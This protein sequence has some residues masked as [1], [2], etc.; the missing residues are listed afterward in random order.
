MNFRLIRRPGPLA[1]AAGLALGLAVAGTSLAEP[2]DHDH[3]H[4]DLG[5]SPRPEHGGTVA[6]TDR[7]RFEVVFKADGLIL[8][9]RGNGLRPGA[10]SG[11]KGRAYFLLP[12]AS[13][14]SDP[15]E[16]RPVSTAEGGPADALGLDA[17][18]GGLPA[19]GTRV[20]I[21]VWKLP[22]P[23]EKT[24]QFTLPFA[25]GSP[26]KVVA[27]AAT[28]E[29][30]LGI[31][32][33]ET[34]PV[35]GQDL[36][37]MGGPLRVTRGEE[38]RLYLCCRGCLPKVE[39]APERSFN[40]VL[41]AREATGDDREAVTSQGTCPISD[42]DLDAMGGPIEVSRGGR[43][44]FVCCPACI[45]AVKEDAATYFGTPPGEAGNAQ[46]HDREHDHGPRG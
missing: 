32:A 28:A 27:V 8:Y 41:S 29:D 30:R 39:A 18:L 34:C 2:Q 1:A 31:S 43:S 10:V 14:Y 38:D 22:D 36:G 40:S 16:L 35:S 25:I 3:G 11:L 9:P 17:N 7:H 12:G 13:E 4:H 33:Q 46:G 15:Y 5:R 26:A 45:P 42:A 6:E 21:Q 20:T 24:A 23:A 19:E 44:V 37:A